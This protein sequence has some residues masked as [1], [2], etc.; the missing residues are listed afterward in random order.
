MALLSRPTLLRMSIVLGESTAGVSPG[1]AVR[2][3]T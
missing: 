3:V 1:V 2:L